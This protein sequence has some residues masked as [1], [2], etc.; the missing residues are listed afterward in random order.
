[1]A[2]SQAEIT[3][4]LTAIRKARDSGV[5]RVSHGDEETMFRS[6]AEMNSII[7]DLEAQLA[8]VSGTPKR[9]RFFYPRQSSKGY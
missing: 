2:L 5:L 6:L 7:A 3:A 1:V 8:A 4:R 9:K